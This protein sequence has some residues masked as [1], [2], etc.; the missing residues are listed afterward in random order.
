MKKKLRSISKALK[1]NKVCKNCGKKYSNTN[2]NHD[3]CVVYWSNWGV[4][5][6]FEE[7]LESWHDLYHGVAL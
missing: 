6:L 5:V 1:R 2:N 7:H 4:D 3:F